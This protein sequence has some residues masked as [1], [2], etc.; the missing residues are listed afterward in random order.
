MSFFSYLK[1]YA[2]LAIQQYNDLFV[3]LIAYPVNA[4]E[5][6]SQTLDLIYSIPLTFVNFPDG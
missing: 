1:I 6:N 3:L 2:T 5:N 4:Y